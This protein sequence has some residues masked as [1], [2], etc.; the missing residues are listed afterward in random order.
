MDWKS[1]TI[2]QKDRPE[3]I[4]FLDLKSINFQY[5]REIEKAILR[6]HESGWYIRGKEGLKFEQEF[7]NYCG[8]KEAIG[9]ANGLD[10]LT[11]IF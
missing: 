11:L 5:K 3:M 6:V 10:A 8:S 2:S 7:A 9:V 1:S 4:K